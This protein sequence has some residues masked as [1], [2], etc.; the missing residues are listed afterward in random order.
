MCMTRNKHG[1]SLIELMVA[2]FISSIVVIAAYSLM[3]GSTDNFHDQDDS[4]LLEANL[5]N[6]ELLVQRDLSRVGYHAPFTRDNYP[7]A[8]TLD[9][10]QVY[11][12]KSGITHPDLAHNA[13]AFTRD[14]AKKF[15][16]FSI[17]ADLTDYYG[18]NI[19]A[20]ANSTTGSN[21]VLTLANAVELPLSAHTFANFPNS[22][23]ASFEAPAGEM[24]L[25]ES[26]KSIFERIFPYAK[27]VYLVSSN[28]YSFITPV[29]DAECTNGATGYTGKITV[30]LCDYT[31]F[32]FTG[33]GTNDFADAKLFPVVSVTYTTANCGANNTK[34]LI[35]CYGDP[36]TSP[37][38]LIDIVPTG[39]EYYDRDNCQV[40]LSN[41]LKFNV[42]PLSEDH[43]IY[44]SADDTSGAY[45][46][47]KLKEVTAFYFDI[48]AYSSRVTPN[49][50]DST[51]Q[52]TVSGNFYY[53]AN[54]QGHII[55][56]AS[57]TAVLKTTNMTTTEAL[58]KNSDL[59]KVVIRKVIPPPEDTEK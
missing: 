48:E 52:N 26:Y 29:I 51:K 25:G 54:H 32:N 57:G 37:D 15:T 17:L 8:S 42:V 28:N 19:T 30:D 24:A 38:K 5:R 23:S 33:D 55:A 6:A 49:V 34:C 45:D 39:T 35:R 36:F 59:D 1:F 40:L 16:T 3:T 14:N 7:T 21:K 50:E 2:V 31:K 10:K 9:H 43:P 53:D 27:A 58:A 22:S 12:C 46:A 18:F 13:F 11:I 47:I 56:S 41:L 20:T 44:S 4:R